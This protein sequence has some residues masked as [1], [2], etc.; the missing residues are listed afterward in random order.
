MSTETPQQPG[1]DPE[2]RQPGD[3]PDPDRPDQE[4]QRNPQREPRQQE[5]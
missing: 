5:S 3:R 2:R 1:Q 4:T